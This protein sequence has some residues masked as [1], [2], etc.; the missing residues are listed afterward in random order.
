VKLA[1]IGSRSFDDYDYFKSVIKQEFEE[2]PI[3]I[4]IS[5]ETEGTGKLGQRFAV[6]NNIPKKVIYSE[7]AKYGNNA[8]IMQIIDIVK[9]SDTVLAFWDGQNKE[10][11]QSIDQAI[12][13]DKDIIVK[14]IEA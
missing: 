11:K 2:K 13:F 1:V 10:T 4:I 5:S 8:S 12:R 6:E 3:E 14:L 9:T 7:W